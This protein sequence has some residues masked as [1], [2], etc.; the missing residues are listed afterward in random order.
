AFFERGAQHLSHRNRALTWGN[1]ATLLKERYVSIF[2]VKYPGND[3]LTRVPTLEEQKLTI[4]PANQY[5]DSDDPLRPVLNP[6]R[7]Q[8]MAEWLQQKASPWAEIK[9]NN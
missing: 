2:D 5:N 1:M 7:L 9:I 8:E 4:I 3:E 6:A